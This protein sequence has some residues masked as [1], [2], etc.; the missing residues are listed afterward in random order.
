ML[1]AIHTS[2]INLNSKAIKHLVAT[3]ATGVGNRRQNCA[4][5]QPSGCTRAA[6]ALQEAQEPG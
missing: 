4:A 6:R 3:H 2:T 5:P 1:P